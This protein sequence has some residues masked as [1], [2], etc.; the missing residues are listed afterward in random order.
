MTGP[1]RPTAP[2]DGASATRST[3]TAAGPTDPTGVSVR[4]G[5]TPSLPVP[6][7]STAATGPTASTATLAVP[8][9]PTNSTTTGAT[10]STR[11]T[12]TV[13]KSTSPTGTAARSAGP[14]G[15]T[16]PTGVTDRISPTGLAR[17][18]GLEARDL[19][20]RVALVTGAGSG[21]GR[22][23]AVLLAEAGAHV[24]VSDLDG[25]AAAATA[26]AITD[27]GSQAGADAVALDVR[28]PVAVDAAVAEVVA[29]HGRIDVLVNVA[30]VMHMAQ[31]GDL[32]DADLDAVLATN[33]K[34][35][36]H[37]ARAV[38]P[39]M[40]AR[41]SGSIVNVASTAVDVARPG[42]FAY[43]ASK[44]ALVQLTRILAV[45]VGPAGVRVNA[46][47]PGWVPTGMTGRHYIR[48]DGTVDDEAF[49][50]TAGPM[51]ALSPLGRIGRPDD[52]AHAILYLASDAADFVTG[53]ILR[54]NGGVS[55]P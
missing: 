30:G 6:T 16:D 18:A 9:G 31:V 20:G 5:P 36:F 52:I 27:Q 50:R 41:G 13:A 24:V 10:R 37:L 17:A 8:T 53:Q 29:I 28:D 39:H 34:G 46:V 33:L 21:I 49:E 40:T 12:G 3:R 38:V 32:A 19:Y 25:S 11:P 15:S 43:S 2:T 23:T 22:A 14:T 4:P 35:P 54:P 1:T 26:A 47:A 55:M 44:A 51:R 42:L 45:E 48:P 7:S